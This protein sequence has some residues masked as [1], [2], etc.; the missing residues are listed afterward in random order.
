MFQAMNKQMDDVQ[1]EFKILSK[2]GQSLVKDSTQEAV[3]EMLG[4][5]KVMKERLIKV[6][7][8]VPDRMTKLKSLKPQVESVESGMTDVSQ[9]LD[10]AEDILDGNIVDGNMQNTAS[11][12]EKHQ[13]GIFLSGIL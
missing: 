10:K 6:K 8:E 4:T 5:L 2:T 12:L 7:K 13:V 11:E 1:N 3:S 9:W